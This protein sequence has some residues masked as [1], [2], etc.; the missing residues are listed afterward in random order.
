MKEYL[1]GTEKNQYMVLKSIAQMMDGKRHGEGAGIKLGTM[2]EEW[3]N[4]DNMTKDEHKNLKMAMTYLNKF[5]DSVNARLNQ[6]EQDIIAKKLVKFDF[7]LMDDFT[8]KKIFRDIQERMVNAVVPR[9]QFYDWTNEI[10]AIKCNGCT[11]S[12]NE[13]ELH[14]IFDDNFIPE[15]GYDLPSCPY[16]FAK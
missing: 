6:R 12:C 5:L 3:K 14:K 9:E 10:M 4:H 13:C 1:N 11:K 8:M 2:L 16:A 7:R 15:S